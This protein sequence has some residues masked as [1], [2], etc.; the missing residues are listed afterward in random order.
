MSKY[1]SNMSCEIC[2]KIEKSLCKIRVGKSEHFI[3]YDC[4]AIWCA[5]IADF[6]IINLH[7]EL[8]NL[9]I[10]IEMRAITNRRE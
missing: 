1:M 2:H 6:A 5:D 10:E 4:A 8:K 7:D 3:C 9:G